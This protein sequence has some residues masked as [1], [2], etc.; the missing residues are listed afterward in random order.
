MIVY[1]TQLQFKQ[2]VQQLDVTEVSD[3][4]FSSKLQQKRRADALCFALLFSPLSHYS[5]KL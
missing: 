3:L 4:L 1:H 5:A 2:S